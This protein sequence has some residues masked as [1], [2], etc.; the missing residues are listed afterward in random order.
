MFKN[1]V[2]SEIG[3]INV[4]GLSFCETKSHN[5]KDFSL[6]FNIITCMLKPAVV[7]KLCSNILIF[8]VIFRFL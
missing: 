5:H 2:N 7:Q 8:K 6:R 4:M 1:R 3:K